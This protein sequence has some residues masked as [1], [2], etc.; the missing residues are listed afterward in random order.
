MHS[1]VADTHSPGQICHLLQLLWSRIL[2]G[3]TE[4]RAQ[5]STVAESVTWLHSLWPW[6]QGESRRALEW[7]HWGAPISI[8]LSPKTA[9]CLS[10][11][12]MCQKVCDE[13]GGHS[14]WASWPLAER[15]Q[16]NIPGIASAGPWPFVSLLKAQPSMSTLPGAPGP[17]IINYEGI[18]I[19]A[20]SSQGEEACSF[21]ARTSVLC[22]K[23]NR[24]AFCFTLMSYRE[25]LTCSVQR[26]RDSQNMNLWGSD[27][28]QQRL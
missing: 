24:S 16:T 6:H 22:K 1:V 14:R 27:L 28:L 19:F 2:Q 7:K 20:G 23:H 10:G 3:N 8:F 9:W 13:A 15:S 5:D 18:F 21:Y 4:V 17:P 12:L 11:R 25:S 26:G